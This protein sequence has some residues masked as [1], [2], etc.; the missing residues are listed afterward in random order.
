MSISPR[1]TAGPG[2]ELAP[3]PLAPGPAFPT[4][5][6]TD[7]VHVRPPTGPPRSPNWTRCRVWMQTRAQMAPA[8]SPEQEP[9]GRHTRASGST[10]GHPDR[11]G[12]KALPE[13]SSPASPGTSAGLPLRDGLPTVSLGGVRC[14]LARMGD[15]GWSKAGGWGCLWPQQW[16]L[17]SREEGPQ[18]WGQWM[19]PQH[20][21]AH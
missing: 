5:P 9:G 7:P 21:G 10:L 15:R 4:R 14:L 3:L 20:G 16:A 8:N 18:R 19:D 1:V 6:P 2:R 17:V 12:G 13:T 11:D